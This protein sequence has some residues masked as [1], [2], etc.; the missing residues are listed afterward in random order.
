M[1][2]R[3]LSKKLLIKPGYRVLVI[4]APAGYLTALN[5]LPEGVTMSETLN[6]DFD[7]VQVFVRSIADANACAPKALTALK[8]NGL[9]WFAYPKKSSKI[10]TDINRDVGW[11]AVTS[12]GWE[13]IASIAIDDTW[14]GIRF[15]KPKQK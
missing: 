13:G 9:L 5:P 7:L 11:D 12:E 3:S 15:V 6:G 8:P 4:N 2:Q 10:K 14:S 1:S